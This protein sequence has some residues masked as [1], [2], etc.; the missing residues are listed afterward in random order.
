MSTALYIEYLTG[1]AVKP[2]THERYV[3][4]GYGSCVGYQLIPYGLR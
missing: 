2:T 3:R 1:V 4:Y